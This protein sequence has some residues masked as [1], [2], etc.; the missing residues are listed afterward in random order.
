[1]P[2]ISDPTGEAA[3]RADRARDDEH[4]ILRQLRN[5]RRALD[6]A[7]T[8][9]NRY[10]LRDPSEWDLAE[11]AEGEPGCVSCARIKGPRTTRW[12]NPIA[13]HTTLANGVR[14]GLC[15]YCYHAAGIG[16]RHTGELPPKEAVEAQ[17]DGRRYKRTG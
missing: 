5:A 10:Q 17:R 1:M 13:R 7:V 6:R 9:A 12:W 2:N 11:A 15:W 8:I 14:V 3:L 16:A 4:E